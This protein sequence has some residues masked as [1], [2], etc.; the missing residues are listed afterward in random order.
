M[1]DIF[2]D[3]RESGL[4]L[5][6]SENGEPLLGAHSAS[7]K[8]DQYGQITVMWVG[9]PLHHSLVSFCAKVAE[10]LDVHGEGTMS[11]VGR[12]FRKGLK[13][14]YE[15]Q[16]WLQAGA[17]PETK[18]VRYECSATPQQRLPTSPEVTERV[19]VWAALETRLPLAGMGEDKPD[20]DENVGVNLPLSRLLT[21]QD[22]LSTL[23]AQSHQAEFDIGA[24]RIALRS[25]HEYLLPRPQA[26]IMAA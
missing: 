3:S 23:I 5:Q 6:L 11:L 15:G 22:E 8:V 24:I 10:Q 21:L 9:L 18:L 19:I 12:E 2:A 17:E 14:I 20:E 16:S 13:N 26:K 4:W 25:L 1:V 7:D